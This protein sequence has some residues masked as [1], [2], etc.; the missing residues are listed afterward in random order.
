MLDM[1]IDI[2]FGTLLLVLACTASP[3]LIAAGWWLEHDGL[4]LLGVVA[5]LAGGALAVM[6][7][8]AKTRRVVR[9]VAQQAHSPG[10]ALRGL[11]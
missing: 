6:R 9:H 1:T 3:A 10:N 7:D 8:N 5:A 11:S 2:T 4:G